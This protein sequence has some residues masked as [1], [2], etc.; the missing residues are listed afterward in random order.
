MMFLILQVFFFILFNLAGRF[1]F[2]SAA[3]IFDML[4]AEILPSGETVALILKWLVFLVPSV[5]LYDTPVLQFHPSP[6]AQ[7]QIFLFPFYAQIAPAGQRGSDAG[8]S[9]S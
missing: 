3:L 6:D 5:A 4:N 9:A 1:L 8:S 7:V 2:Y